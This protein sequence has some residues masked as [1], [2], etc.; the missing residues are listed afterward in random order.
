M[1]NL[2][3]GRCTYRATGIVSSKYTTNT[4]N[5][6]IQTSADLLQHSALPT[7]LFAWTPWNLVLY[8]TAKRY[9]TRINPDCRS[10]S[11]QINMDGL[12]VDE[13]GWWM[14]HFIVSFIIIR[15]C[16]YI[17]QCHNQSNCVKVILSK[18]EVICHQ[19]YPLLM[20]RGTPGPPAA[21]RW[22]TSAVMICKLCWMSSNL[23]RILRQAGLTGASESRAAPYTDSNCTVIT[24]VVICRQAGKK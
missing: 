2:T 5:I 13:N 11:P 8:N 4:G 19:R 16:T 9:V 14:C 12:K 21:G 24:A 23:A 17:S 22:P 18:N 7:V 6:R 10:S 3:P 15:Y 20:G 1:Y